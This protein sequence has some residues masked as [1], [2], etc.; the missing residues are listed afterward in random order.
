MKIRAG[1]VS[2]SSSSSFCAFGIS[3]G[4]NAGEVFKGMFQELG[5]EYDY[6]E[7]INGYESVENM[8]E[9]ALENIP[10]FSDFTYYG[11]YESDTIYFGRK[12]N[13][14]DDNVTFGEFRNN[15]IEALEPFGDQPHYIEE[16]W[17]NY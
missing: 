11:N 16:A 13:N 17:M 2:N 1:F 15:V 8:I 5:L 4:E 6:V 9:F 14:V 7:D 12:Y 3:L 10:M